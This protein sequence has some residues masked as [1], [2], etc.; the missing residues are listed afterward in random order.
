MLNSSSLYG[1]GNI[2]SSGFGLYVHVPFCAKKCSYCAFNVS[3][4]GLH[5]QSDYFKALKAEVLYYLTNGPFELQGAGFDTIYFGGGTPSLV[6]P[7]L[8]ADF[9]AST[10]LADGAE[11]SIEVNPESVR[12]E[13]FASYVDS[14]ITR[15]SIGVQS[16]DD[17]VLQYYGRTHDMAGAERAIELAV[18]TEG[19][20]VGIDLVYGSDVEDDKSWSKTVS[21]ATSLAKGISHVSAYALGIEQRTKLHYDKAQSQSEDILS[22]RYLLASEAFEGCGLQNYEISNWARPD[23]RSRHNLNYWMWGDYLGVGLGAHS[24]FGRSRWWNGPSLKGYLADVQIK[25]TGFLAGEELTDT[26]VEAERLMLA[27][28]IQGG[29]SEKELRSWVS[30]V[31]GEDLLGLFEVADGRASLK[32]RG[33]LVADGVFR[34]LST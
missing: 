15:V 27:L 13:L 21:K 3:H 23:G 20:A 2:G 25:G 28:R 16:F 32:P 34:A 4:N 10:P 1:V 24:H 6:D 31:D 19:L 14:G 22:E 12:K 7:L 18:R 8:I 9:L 5:L 30:R 11:V 33:R 26:Q 17:K 29:L